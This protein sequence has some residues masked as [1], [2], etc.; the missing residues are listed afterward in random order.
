MHANVISH[1][2]FGLALITVVALYV[3]LAAEPM[4]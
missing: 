1:G 4:E 3:Y 2:L